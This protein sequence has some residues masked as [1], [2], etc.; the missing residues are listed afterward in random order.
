MVE[1]KP[2]IP[3]SPQNSHEENPGME[4]TK[5]PRCLVHPLELPITGCSG[6]INYTTR[7]P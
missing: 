2:H 6:G 5:I 3:P 4:T 1:E 7:N